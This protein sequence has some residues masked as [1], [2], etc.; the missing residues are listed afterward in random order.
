MTQAFD[1]QLA[2]GLLAAQNYREF[3]A[4][5]FDLLKKRNAHFGYSYFAKRAGFSARS[6]PREVVTGRKRITANSLGKFIGGFD[7]TNELAE[8]FTLLVMEEEP[9]VNINDLPNAEITELKARTRQ[10]LQAI[11]AGENG[12]DNEE[13]VKIYRTQEWP[14]IYASLHD[15]VGSSLSEVQARSGLSKSVCKRALDNMIQQELVKFDEASQTYFCLASNLFFFKLGG[16]AFFKNYFVDQMQRAKDKA[17][18]NFRNPEALF[19]TSVFSVDSRKMPELVNELRAVLNKYIDQAEKPLGDHIAKL[20]VAFW[21][22]V[23]D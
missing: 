4:T 19:F 21:D 6:Y 16:D 18:I 23:K 15:S 7:L 10:R 8:Y 12:A 22:D 9:E 1:K 5:A 3:L 13:T 20:A 2:E 17:T 11:L 14:E